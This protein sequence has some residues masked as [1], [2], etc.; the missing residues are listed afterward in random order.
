LRSSSGEES[1]A[2]VETSSGYGDAGGGG[3]GESWTGRDGG[4]RQA[5]ARLRKTLYRSVPLPATVLQVL[6]ILL[7]PILHP[8]EPDKIVGTGM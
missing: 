2:G 5:E 6:P 8:P 4:Q 1:A 7:S 3:I